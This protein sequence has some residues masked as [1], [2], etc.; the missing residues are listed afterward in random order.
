M[1]DDELLRAVDWV[2][3]TMAMDED[4][5]TLFLSALATRGL[6]NVGELAV[7]DPEAFATLYEGARSMVDQIPEADLRSAGQ[8]K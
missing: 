2:R 4:T 7:S 1:T 6:A 8:G 3:R 5:R